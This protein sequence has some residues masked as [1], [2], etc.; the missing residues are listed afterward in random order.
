MVSFCIKLYTMNFCNMKQL[1][2]S[3]KRLF[4]NYLLTPPGLSSSAW[5]C[6]APVQFTRHTRSYGGKPCSIDIM[7]PTPLTTAD[8]L[9]W[10]MI[11]A[12]RSINFLWQE[13][14]GALSTR[15][16]TVSR[17]SYFKKQIKAL[18][19]ELRFY[20]RQ[21]NSYAKMSYGNYE[22]LVLMH[23]L[24]LKISPATKTEQKNPQ[25]PPPNKNPG[26]SIKA[27]NV[28]STRVI[29]FALDLPDSEVGL[30]T[31]RRNE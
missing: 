10:N 6:T 11:K 28:L 9:H 31:G 12:T 8:I 14:L 25:Q 15:T 7:F 30:E 20:R 13:S 5:M 24:L 4:T 16:F 27:I 26:R 18:G 21:L 17:N 22:N 2:T 3:R 23:T 29:H 19:K 1:N